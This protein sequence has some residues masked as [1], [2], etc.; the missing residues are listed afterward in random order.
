MSIRPVFR[1]AVAG[2][3]E[4]DV[5]LIEIVFKH[6][7][8]NK[9]DFQLLEEADPRQTDILIVN[10]GV[11][12]GLDALSALRAGTRD[13]PSIS[14][15]P[16][17]AQVAARH[18][19][20]IDRLT[21]Q[22]LPTL[23]RVVETEGLERT[24]VPPREAVAVPAADA[25]SAA[26]SR[27][28][29]VAGIPTVAQ[30]ILVDPPDVAIA[31][32]PLAPPDALVLRKAATAAGGTKAAPGYD[33]G[34][35]AVGGAE[36]T[37]DLGAVSGAEPGADLG[38]DSPADPDA[39]LAAE[40]AAS[41]DI[42]DPAVVDTGF[43]SGEVLAARVLDNTLTA[44]VQAAVTAGTDARGH[45]RRH[46]A[47]PADAD[48]SFGG[49]SPEP[50]AWHAAPAAVPSRPTP[51]GPAPAVQAAVPIATG[52]TAA[53]L[54]AAARQ[55]YG[56][57]PF[58]L[59]V[60]V[61]DPSVAAQQQLARALKSLGLQVQ[62]VV[63]SAAALECAAQRHYDLIITEHSLSDADGFDLIRAF[64]RR[65]AYRT[66]PVL[67]LRS[68]LGLLDRPRAGLL[69]N[70]GLLT[71]PLTRGALAKVVASTLRDCIALDHLDELLSIGAG[72]SPASSD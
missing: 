58:R 52:G 55:E 29:F 15:L 35:A 7:Q 37:A 16:R 28:A 64:R 44:T 43:A 48:R 24:R 34:L 59:Q 60:L 57:Q 1:I 5:R 17:G 12:A 4:R 10:P 13:V 3:D 54:L 36:R 72:R 30:R 68:R 9:Y 40:L 46:G 33:P 26:A 71:K 6:S 65:P 21:L 53:A 2:L 51:A 45:D 11:A 31:D 39:A 47:R 61:A 38:A 22:L 69:G 20:T 23:N 70:V 18:A 49:G 62:C 67:L 32:V 56:S 41:L 50:G 14:A 27:A 42:L 63:S 8:Y 25:S 19:I 66:T